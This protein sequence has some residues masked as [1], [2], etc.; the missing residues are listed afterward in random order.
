MTWSLSYLDLR[1]SNPT[2][3]PHKLYDKVIDIIHVKGLRIVDYIRMYT[4]IAYRLREDILESVGI[5]YDDLIAVNLTE[6]Q[7]K[8]IIKLIKANL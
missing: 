8:K 6:D 1:L 7:G 2:I 5:S 4:K 3:N